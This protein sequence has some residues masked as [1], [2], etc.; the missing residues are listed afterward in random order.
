M[1][2]LLA[3][4]RRLP[5]NHRLLSIHRPSATTATAF[6]PLSCLPRS[7]LLTQ[8]FNFS[9]STPSFSSCIPLSTSSEA[10]SNTM[11]DDKTKQHYLADSPPTVVRLEIKSHF[12][13]LKDA[14]LRKYAHY[15]SRFVYPGL[16]TRKLH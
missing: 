14:K 8:R 4:L 16:F 7:S 6:L 12:D 2:P 15:L 5:S 11:M 1:L 3:A 9:S 13:S 10:A